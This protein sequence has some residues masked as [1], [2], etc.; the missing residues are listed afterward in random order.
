MNN[1]KGEIKDNFICLPHIMTTEFDDISWVGKVDVSEVS[2]FVRKSKKKLF[3]ESGYFIVEHKNIREI[4]DMH[5]LLVLNTSSC[6]KVNLR[7]NEAISSSFLKKLTDK[8]EKVTW[9][10]NVYFYIDR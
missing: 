10:F 7:F 4:Q 9:S 5:T 6:S 3:K 1:I 2:E 8:L